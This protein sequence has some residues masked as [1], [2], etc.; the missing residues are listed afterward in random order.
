[1]K[2]EAG[3]IYKD[4]NNHLRLIFA[5][6]G[7][8]ANYAYIYRTNI[9]EDIQDAN[10]SILPYD[11][12][13]VCIDRVIPGYISDILKDDLEDI[14]IMSR[15]DFNKVVFAINQYLLGQIIMCDDKFMYKEDCKRLRTIVFRESSDI[16]IKRQDQIKI[17]ELLEATR[18]SDKIKFAFNGGVWEETEDSCN[19]E[20]CIEVDPSNAPDVEKL[21]D[22]LN[23]AEKYNIRFN[24]GDTGYRGGSGELMFNLLSRNNPKGTTSGNP[25]KPRKSSK[26]SARHLRN[27]NNWW[28]TI[29]QIIEISNMSSAKQVADRYRVSASEGYIIYSNARRLMGYDIPVGRDVKYI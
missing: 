16:E 12:Y 15:N 11:D 10:I 9:Y 14:E 18:K 17:N 25:S 19:Y 8:I 28:F 21:K 5:V 26:D 4:K 1:M 22:V 2:L 13:Y 6:N 7:I 3:H 24:Y 29:T 20:K 27:V 23:R